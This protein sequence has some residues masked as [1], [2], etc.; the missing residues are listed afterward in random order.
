M[1]SLFMTSHHKSDEK[2]DFSPLFTF[3]KSAKG[4]LS[5]FERYTKI[6]V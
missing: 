4:M 2:F 5:L 6:S 1:T 3:F